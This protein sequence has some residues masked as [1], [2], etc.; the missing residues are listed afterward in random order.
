M[1]ESR[2]THLKLIAVTGAD[3]RYFDLVAEQ[4]A[5]IRR[6]AQGATLPLA[7]LDG[8]LEAAQVEALKGWGAKVVAPRWPDP[9]TARRYA[10]RDYLRINLA[11]PRLDLLFPDY[12]VI[13]WLDGDAWLQTFD[14]ITL[15]ARVAAKGKLAIVS[16]ASR[17]QTH[18]I[19]LRRRLFGWVE[20]RGIL[21]KNARRARLPADVAWSLVDRP[22]L[23]TGA[24]ALS[25]TAPHWEA[26]R[27][28]QARC[29]RHGR[30]FTS[31][32]LALALAVYLDGLPFE[33]LP[34]TCNYMGPWRVDAERGLLVHHF[35]PYDP[36]S[37]VHM[38]A[39]DDLRRDSGLTVPGLD[40]A[41]RAI[42]L[43]LR[44][45]AFRARFMTEDAPGQSPA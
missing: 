31:D 37:V 21:F 23:N 17:L 26:W 11:K 24:Y 27:A 29:I 39:R 45:P 14:A 7:V 38:V 12:D 22:V 42:D 32:Q 6:L 40:M 41:D 43:P 2:D 28:W 30:A 10:G 13:V 4:V 16:Q 9:D 8:G 5:S 3:A 25:R 34:E 44:F 1:N 18:H 20:P 36:V 19:A 15:F 33:A 35:A